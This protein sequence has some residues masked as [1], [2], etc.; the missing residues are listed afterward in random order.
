MRFIVFVDRIFCSDCYY[1]YILLILVI[2]T[3]LVGFNRCLFPIIANLPFLATTTGYGRLSP[4]VLHHWPT[5]E[6]CPSSRSPHCI[7]KRTARRRPDTA[8]N[9][10]ENCSP[11]WWPY[12]D[13]H[14]NS[15]LS[16]IPTRPPGIS[17][18]HL[19][20][21]HDRISCRQ[22][23]GTSRLHSR[24]AGTCCG[25]GNWSDEAQWQGGLGSSCVTNSRWL[26]ALPHQDYRAKSRARE[27][28]ASTE[29]TPTTPCNH[30]T[31]LH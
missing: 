13:R 12:F 11:I 24:I 22:A 9:S 17:Q 28:T 7:S 8:R 25:P 3:V 1:R 10:D 26:S 29:T 20:S 5:A 16:C 14:W 18:H 19:R 21:S 30:A 27:Q 23:T 6:Y 2:C 4:P 15:H 31:R